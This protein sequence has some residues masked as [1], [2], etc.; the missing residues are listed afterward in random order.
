MTDSIP[1]GM[2]LIDSR[3]PFASYENG[4]VIGNQ[5]IGPFETVTIGYL[6]EAL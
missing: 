3:V 6:A 4:T 5:E 2:V 1:E